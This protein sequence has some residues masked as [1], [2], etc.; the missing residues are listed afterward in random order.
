M[1]LEEGFSSINLGREGLSRQP[2]S[3]GD[4]RPKRRTWS[5]GV[6]TARVQRPGAMATLY[7]HVP[8]TNLLINVHP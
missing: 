3:K 4:R 1:L 5:E 6:I 7:S 2:F 8:V